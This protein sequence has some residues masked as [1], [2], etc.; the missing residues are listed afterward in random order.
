MKNLSILLLSIT[1]LSISAMDNNFGMPAAFAAPQLVPAPA[2]QPADDLAALAQN[3][4]QLLQ[5]LVQQ[6]QLLMTLC[7][8]NAQLLAALIASKHM[9]PVAAPVALPAQAPQLSWTHAQNWT[10][11]ARAAETLQREEAAMVAQLIDPMLAK[12]EQ[13][14]KAELVTIVEIDHGYGQRSEEILTGEKLRTK[15]DSFVAA[16]SK[17]ESLLM[18]MLQKDNLSESQ[19]AKALALLTTARRKSAAAKQVAA[20]DA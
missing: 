3:N 7:Q 19:S 18:D 13:N 15:V 6:N 20:L 8:N 4:Q 5:T 1:T 9:A 10:A 16:M 17:Q 12:I 14:L 11:M 2:A